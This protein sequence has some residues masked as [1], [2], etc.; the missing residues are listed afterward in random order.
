MAA[1][2]GV[3]L[4]SGQGCALPTRLYV[5][6]EV[7]DTFR[8]KLLARI[9]RGTVGD[10]ADPDTEVGPIVSEKQFDEIMEAIFHGNAERVLGL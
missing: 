4:L 5:Q 1:A 9:D 3:M 8:E 6:D 2:L 10:P 7:Y